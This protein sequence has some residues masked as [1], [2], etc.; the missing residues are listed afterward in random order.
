MG[1]DLCKFKNIMNNKIKNYKNY[2]N[3]SALKQSYWPICNL[4]F[5][6]PYHYF[7]QNLPRSQMNVQHACHAIRLINL[8]K[9]HEFFLK[10]IS[11]CY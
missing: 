4:S 7:S 3:Y 6:I 9:K 8:K 10:P 5:F 11:Y 2:N 1:M